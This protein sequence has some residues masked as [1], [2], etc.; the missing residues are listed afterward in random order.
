MYE[1]VRRRPDQ[2]GISRSVEDMDVFLAASRDGF[3]AVREMPV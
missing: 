1:L 2:T 3:T